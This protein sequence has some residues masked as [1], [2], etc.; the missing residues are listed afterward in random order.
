MKFEI[1]VSGYDLFHEGYTICIA[2]DCGIIKGY[3][4]KQPLITS[5]QDNWSKG[6]YRYRPTIGQ[7]GL[8]KVRIYSTIVHYLFRSIDKKYDE[9]DLVV[10]RD[11]AWHENDIKQ[12][13]TF[14]LEKL[15]GRKIKSITFK[16]LSNSS[17]A[18]GYAYLMSK[19]KY[20]LLPSYIEININDIE[21]FLKRTL[22]KK[23]KNV[24]GINTES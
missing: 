16:K 7:R 22:Q 4:L 9:I 15:Q 12:N 2:S 13:L 6:I 8:L 10:C 3:K 18:H 20:N 1:D 11:F 19:D 14:F 21:P 17:N 5:I 23:K 24:K